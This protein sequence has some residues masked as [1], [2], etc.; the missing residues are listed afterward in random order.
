MKRKLREKR[1]LQRDAVFIQKAVNEGY[2]SKNDFHCL[3]Q[4]VDN[5]LN[6]KFNVLYQ[7]SLIDDTINS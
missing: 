1:L 5:E 3:Y 4:E 6:F 7:S 2:I